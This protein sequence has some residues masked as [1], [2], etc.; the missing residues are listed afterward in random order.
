MS[1][2]RRSNLAAH[3]VVN[4]DAEGGYERPIRV[5]IETVRPVLEVFFAPS[6]RCK[7]RRRQSSLHWWSCSRWRLPAW[8]LDKRSTSAHKRLFTSTFAVKNSCC[9]S[10]AADGSLHYDSRHFARHRP[11]CRS[12]RHANC[13]ANRLKKKLLPNTIQSNSIQLG[14]AKCSGKSIN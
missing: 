10:S 5:P 1:A 2:V 12:L 9:S 13:L 11:Q 14:Q 8:H 7:S 3:A 4:E 6:P